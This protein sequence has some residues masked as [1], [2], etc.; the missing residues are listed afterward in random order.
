MT[1]L[2]LEFGDDEI[3]LATAQ[4]L[5]FGRSADLVVDDANMYLHRTLGCF[6]WDGGAW[7]LQNLGRFIPI[8]VV[9]RLGS[10]RL[11]IGPGDAALIGFGEF[12]V[13]FSAGT[14]TYELVGA[15]AEPTAIETGEHEPT[16]TVEYA[17]VDLNAEQ[18]LLVVCLAESLLRGDEDWLV[19]MPSNRDVAARLGW[20]ITKFNRK[21]DYLCRR[22]AEQGV[23]GMRGEDGQQATVRRQRLVQVLTARGTVTAADLALLPPDPVRTV[24]PRRGA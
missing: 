5:T 16:D 3:V 10:A 1:R 14:E 7:V 17:R 2:F 23:S 18:R 24:G 4:S 8:A 21:L 20:P 9:D 13:R 6:V 12:L 22:L 19:R 11:H 15:L